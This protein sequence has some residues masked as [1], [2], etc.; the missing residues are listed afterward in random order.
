[1]ANN[2]IDV[3][4]PA[5]EIIKGQKVTCDPSGNPKTNGES[6][7]GGYKRTPSKSA[8]PEVTRDGSVGKEAKD[9]VGGR[10]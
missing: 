7:P 9:N 6:V 4:G 8:A 3:A 10:S 5:S 1:M 2:R